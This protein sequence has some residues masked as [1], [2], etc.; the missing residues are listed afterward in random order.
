MIGILGRESAYT[1]QHLTMEDLRASNLDLVPSTFAF[2]DMPVPPVPSPGVT[3]L[4]RGAPD[5]D[6]EATATSK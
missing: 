2:G 3:T 6:R 1:G 5:L 4:N